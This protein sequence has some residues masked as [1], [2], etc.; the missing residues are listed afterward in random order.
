MKPYRFIIVFLFI[1]NLTVAQNDNLKPKLD[2]Q[3]SKWHQAA[4]D[5]D[6]KTYR[7][8][9]TEDAIFIGTDPTEYWQGQDFINFAKPYFDRGKAWTFRKLERH[10]YIDKSKQVAWFDELLDTQM[11]ICQGSGVLVQVNGEWKIKHYVLSITIPNENVDKVKA[12]K[13]EFDK[14][15]IEKY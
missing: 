12:L 7:S 6:L 13:A 8:L 14:N 5:A 11:G 15:L 1:A 3:I 10:I 4:A 2:E 9:M